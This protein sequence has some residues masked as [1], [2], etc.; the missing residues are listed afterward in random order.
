M[1]VDSA[2]L[3]EPDVGSTFPGQR[4]PLPRRRS[5]LSFRHLAILDVVFRHTLIRGIWHADDGHDN[6][7]TFG[8]R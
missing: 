1:G 7:P 5:Y 4:P 8:E 2:C 3:I 6:H